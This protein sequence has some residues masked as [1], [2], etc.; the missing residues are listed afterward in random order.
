MKWYLIE[1]CTTSR[2]AMFNTELKAETMDDAVREGLAI[3]DAL[4]EHDQKERE[5]VFVAYAEPD[6]YGDPDLDKTE[7]V[8]DLR[9]V[10]R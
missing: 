2:A 7:A 3:Y 1:D 9:K 5:A 10:E 4:T 8:I 6:E